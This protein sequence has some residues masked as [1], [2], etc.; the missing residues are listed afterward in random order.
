LNLVSGYKRRYRAKLVDENTAGTGPSNYFR[1]FNSTS[2]IKVQ[3]ALPF[4][5]GCDPITVAIDSHGVF[6]YNMSILNGTI[7]YLMKITA[8]RSNF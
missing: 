7:P 3:V 6:E 8:T 4:F 5:A 2:D 1:E